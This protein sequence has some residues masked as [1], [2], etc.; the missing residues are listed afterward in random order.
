MQKQQGAG[1]QQRHRKDVQKVPR[2]GIGDGMRA[3]D[4]Q[5]PEQVG[6]REEP[7]TLNP[8]AGGVS[9]PE[10]EPEDG[11]QEQSKRRDGEIVSKNEPRCGNAPGVC[12]LLSVDADILFHII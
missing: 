11:E 9:A 4:D 6:G 12:R 10:E 3:L 8:D 1:E 2:H 5:M 7:D